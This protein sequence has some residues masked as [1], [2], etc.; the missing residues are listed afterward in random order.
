MKISEAVLVFFAQY[1]YVLLL[2]LQSLNV[3]QRR[4]VGAA[5]T[6]M[7]L[8][9]GGFFVTSIVGSSKGMTF[10]SVWWGFVFAGPAG[11]T[12]AIAIHPWLVRRFGGKP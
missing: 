2:G 12:T 1:A 9:V 7:L 8:G 10:S 5:V 4:Y 3:H 11:I 6:S